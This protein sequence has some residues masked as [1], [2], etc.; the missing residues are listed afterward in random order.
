MSS[1]KEQKELFVSDLLGGSI[2]E[3]YTITTIALTS[4]LTYAL[5]KSS[6]SKDSQLSFLND[7]IVNCLT[8]LASITIYSNNINYLHYLTIIPGILIYVISKYILKSGEETTQ[9]KKTKTTSTPNEFLPKK[10][11][12]TAYRAHML[13]ITNL[14]ILAVDFNIFPRRFAKVET[15]GTS[16]MDLGVGSFVFSMGLVNSR[17]LLKESQSKA[18]SNSFLSYLHIIRKSIIKSIP[19]LALGIIRLVSVKQLE[20]QE[21]VTE[22]GIHWNFFITLGL[23]PILLGILDPLFQLLPRNLIGFLIVLIYE[24]GLQ[25]FDLL[26]FILTSDNR[27]NNIV[28]MNKEGIFSFLGYFSIFLF[29]Q[30]FGPTLLTGY[31][32]V[33]NLIY[34][35]H[36]K[37]T[38]SKSGFL[39]FNTT[40][41]LIILTMFYHII[42][43]YFNNSF[44]TT[45]ISR[46]LANLNY[47]LWVVAYNS[48][49][50]LGYNLI[51]SLFPHISTTSYLL[52]STNNNGLLLFLIS[53]LLTGFINMSIN[54]LATTNYISFL[55]LVIYSLVVSLIA[56]ELNKRSIY[57]K[58]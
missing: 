8:L 23:L 29:G 58:L 41:S 4:Y 17:S 54:T 40:N 53:N 42:F 16:L 11:F 1:L 43:Y 10:P 33:N 47:V 49:L 28:T 35:S 22:Y 12:I 24:I 21:H 6:L 5:I 27:L 51:E 19:I 2:S 25:K 26:S 31:P 37:P 45:N 55:I 13:I 30:S 34:P 56:V 52:E 57:I 46:R 39:T 3:I 9:P 20:Y 15:W 7:Y 32:T 18:N 38:K 44:L 50:L 48:T 36:I 14:S